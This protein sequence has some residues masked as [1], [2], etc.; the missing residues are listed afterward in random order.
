VP[1]LVKQLI[2]Y[3][4]DN[5][6]YY[7]SDERVKQFSNKNIFNSR[8]GIARYLIFFYLLTDY[9]PNGRL[10][11]YLREGKGK[12]LSV[13]TLLWIAAQVNIIF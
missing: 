8:I 4:E 7:F 1:I 10:S 6:V 5:L 3:L 13:N 2:K 11:M 9:M 12:D